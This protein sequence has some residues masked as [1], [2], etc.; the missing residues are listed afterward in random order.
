MNCA[1]FPFSGR[2]LIEDRAAGPTLTVVLP[3]IEPE[4]AEI[5]REPRVRP[6]ANPPLRIDATLVFEEAQ[7]T[8]PVISCML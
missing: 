3:L 2:I 7:V 4:E 8:E 1:I 5:I 6:A